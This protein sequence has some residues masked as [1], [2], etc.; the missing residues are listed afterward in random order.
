MKRKVCMKPLFPALIVLLGFIL[1]G[2]T[3][4]VNGKGAVQLPVSPG[5]DLFPTLLRGKVIR[6][7]PDRSSKLLLTYILV[8]AEPSTT[9]T[10]G[11]DIF[12]LPDPGV[13]SFGVPRFA[14][15]NQTREGTNATTDVFPVGTFVTDANGDGDAHFNLDLAG[16][17]SGTYLLQYWWSASCCFPVSYRTG[18]SFGIGF[19]TITVP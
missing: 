13:A 4:Q 12:N 5:W 9:Y 11:F 17:P 14:R 8:G 16:V 10:V 1:L 19:D 7:S 18:T 2:S 6:N 3:T 15:I